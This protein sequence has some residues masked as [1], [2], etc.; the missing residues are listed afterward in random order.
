M[1]YPWRD[2]ALAALDRFMAYVEPDPNSGC[3]LWAGGTSRGG[4]TTTGPSR[5]GGGP[6]GSF[7]VPGHGTVRC[8]V[9]AAV[10]A[11]EMRPGMHTDH[12]CNT[13]LCVRYGPGH[14]QVTTPSENSR[15][16]WNGRRK[17]DRN[18]Q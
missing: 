18:G 9:Y 16:R 10:V 8:G 11:G 1:P 13:H 17:K 4:D 5:K 3:W 12:E 14:L 2:A 6:Y 7:R 15:R